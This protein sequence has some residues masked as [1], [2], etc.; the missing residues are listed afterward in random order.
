MRVGGPSAAGPIA[1]PSDTSKGRFSA[2]RFTM[3]RDHDAARLRCG[4]GKV[5]R[6]TSTNKKTPLP[7]GALLSLTSRTH[8]LTNDT[9]IVFR[10]IQALL[11]LLLAPRRVGHR[12]AAGYRDS[13]RNR[14]RLHLRRCRTGRDD[15]RRRHSLH[16]R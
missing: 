9:R 2:S 4:E 5:K 11:V 10:Q 1:S 6:R 13:G 7:R 16:G 12:L 15:L 3:P 8:L 14:R